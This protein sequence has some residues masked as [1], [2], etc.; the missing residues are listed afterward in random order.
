MSVLKALRQRIAPEL[1]FL[2]TLPPVETPLGWDCGWR[3]P[4][5][6][7]HAFFVARMFGSPATLCTGDFALLSQFVP[8]L[9]TLDRETKHAWCTVGDIAPVDLSL[10]FAYFDR[11]PP[12]HSPITGEGLN[13]EWTVRYAEDD[14]ILDGNVESGNE[15]LFIERSV[16]ADSAETLLHDPSRFLPPVPRGSAEDWAALH[17]PDI[18]AKIALHCFR[19]ANGDGRSIR[20]RATRAEAIAWIAENHPEPQAEILRR[21]E[22]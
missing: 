14:S 2:L 15:I 11:V 16:V 19:C 3:G 1:N 21:I 5:H 10:T 4:E 6:A 9:S 7:W 17:G 8:P 20:N 13:G 12:L 22:A 18:H